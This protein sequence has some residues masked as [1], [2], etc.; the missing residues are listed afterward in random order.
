MLN[1]REILIEKD[2]G[3]PEFSFI[4]NCNFLK[5]T[6]T[7]YD[8]MDFSPTSMALFSIGIQKEKL[9][10]YVMSGG[11]FNIDDIG[12][13]KV[14]KLSEKQLTKKLMEEI[15]VKMS[16]EF[17]KNKEEIINKLFNEKIETAE[18]LERNQQFLTNKFFEF[19]NNNENERY[20]E[21]GNKIEMLNM[22]DVENCVTT[23][24]HRS[25]YNIEDVSKYSES[26]LEKVFMDVAGEIYFGFL[27]NRE[28]IG[29]LSIDLTP[30]IYDPNNM[31]VSTKGLMIRWKQLEPKLS[32]EQINA[33]NN[34]MN[35]L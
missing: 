20:R 35:L 25:I 32:G 9:I 26:E 21:L 14:K 6:I 7:I 31:Y 4:K 13:I 34:P 19:I 30:L 3:F 10:D 24:L 22:S 5:R 12:N 28:K 11:I 18:N 2:E 15:Y 33:L 23:K 1:N 16:L 8:P 29:I 17:A 27:R